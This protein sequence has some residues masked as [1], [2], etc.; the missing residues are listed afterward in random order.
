MTVETDACDT[1]D[2]DVGSRGLGADVVLER[3]L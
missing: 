1:D 3:K 2:D